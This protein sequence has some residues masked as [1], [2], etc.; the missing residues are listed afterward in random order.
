MKEAIN[1]SL[2]EKAGFA[3]AFLVLISEMIRNIIMII[4]LKT[5]RYQL[6]KSFKLNV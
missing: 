1:A 3:T 5:P 2:K 4:K 6:V